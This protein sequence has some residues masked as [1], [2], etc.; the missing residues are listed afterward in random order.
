MSKFGPDLYRERLAQLSRVVEARGL[1]AYI[2]PSADPHLSEYVPERFKAI[3]WL[4]GFSGSAGTLL[5]K[6]TQAELWVDSRYWEQAE[7]QLEGTGVATMRLQGG[8]SG[9]GESLAQSLQDGQTVGVDPSVIS[10]SQYRGLGELLKASGVAL[11]S[12]ESLLDEIWLNRPRLPES[13]IFEHPL[14]FA[15]H[16]R[17]EK[18]AAVRKRM[19]MSGA[20]WYLTSALDEVAWLSNLRAADVS[21]NPVFVAHILVSTSK[22]ILFVRD[23]TLPE[24]I[25]ASLEADGILLAAYTT[26]KSAVDCLP[27]ESRLFL[28]P[29]KSPMSSVLGLGA[30]VVEG[31]SICTELKAVKSAEEAVRI[32]AAMVEDGVALVQFFDWLD[33][34]VREHVLTESE[35]D[36]Q[37]TAARSRRPGF[38]SR[39]FATI[40]AFGPSAALPHYVAVPGEDRR[41]E[42]D[43]LLLLDS[44]GQYLGGT[45]D[46][47]RMVAIGTPTAEQKR[48]V[49]LALKGMIALSVAVFPSGTKPQVLDGIARAPIWA[50]M[51]NYGHGTGHGVGYFLNVHEG[52]QSIAY[53]ALPIASNK[54]VPGMVTSVEPGIYRPG[55][56]G[57]RVENLVLCN[58]CGEN[59]FG[60]FL[61]FETLTLCPI[62]ARCLDIE[63]LSAEE[64]C[65][66]DAY[67]ATVWER[68]S[69]HVDGTARDWLRTH[70][71]QVSTS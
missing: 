25:A 39:S 70:T 66:L 10:L 41:I 2:V 63:M 8:T 22:A 46:I 64:R 7:R 13:Q 17:Q 29:A 48:D 20:D 57:V 27:K 31:T 21:F 40:A 67:H 58:K 12:H 62:D 50:Q 49:T 52:P 33:R 36:E 56:W 30:E 44:G 3:S 35:L 6:P 24:E 16:S 15:V 26:M 61:S 32:R 60:E 11:S 54:M 34:T 19:E 55:Q 65:W 4:T 53:S 38:V 51:L 59:S 68:L 14:E 1:A 18:L 45:T 9:Y 71:Q 47:T 5:V 37:I 28:D 69:P 23:G 42:G 43:G